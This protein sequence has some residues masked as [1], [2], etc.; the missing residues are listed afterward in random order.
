MIYVSLICRNCHRGC[1]N[2]DLRVLPLDIGLGLGLPLEIGLVPGLPLQIGLVLGLPLGKGL[3]LGLPL[4]IG[5]VLGL[6][7]PVFR[8]KYK[9][10]RH[11]KKY[12][13]EESFGDQ[14]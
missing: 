2:I 3:V 10:V 14:V 5:L 6:L 11:L 13:L 7:L 12:P 9:T 4:K 8:K 1:E